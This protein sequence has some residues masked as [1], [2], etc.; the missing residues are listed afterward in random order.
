MVVSIKVLLGKAVLL[1]SAKDC[2]TASA[3]LVNLS[4]FKS[5]MYRHLNKNLKPVADTRRGRRGAQAP[6]MIFTK[7]LVLKSGSTRKFLF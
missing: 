5:R 2:S 7:A 3:S 1:S 6:P 4:C